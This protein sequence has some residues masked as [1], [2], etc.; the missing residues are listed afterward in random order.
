MNLL[1][2]PKVTRYANWRDDLHGWLLPPLLSSE[3][4]VIPRAPQSTLSRFLTQTIRVKIVRNGRMVSY[5]DL[6][7][8]LKPNETLRDMS[9]V[10]CQ[11][12]GKCAGCQYQ[13]SLV[14]HAYCT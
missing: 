5:A 2:H 6:L 11:Y 8:V 13:V 1:N 12:F 3:R 14:P 4:Q 9:R 7:E 10:K